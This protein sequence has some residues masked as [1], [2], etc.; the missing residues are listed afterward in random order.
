MPVN[1]SL[2]RL[3]TPCILLVLMVSGQ[4]VF[5]QRKVAIQTNSPQ[6][7]F[8]TQEILDAL[9]QIGA[10]GKL[11]L[12]VAIDESLGP[13]GYRVEIDEPG[14]VKVIGGDAHG[15]MY[16]ELEVAEQIRLTRDP[17]KVTAC[18]G[19]PYIGKRGLKFNIPLD[20]RAPSYD[21]TGDAAQKNIPVMWEYD[22]WTEFLDNMAR[23][24]YNVLT[25]WSTHPYPTLLPLEEYPGV[26]YDDV[27][28][29]NVEMAH[30]TDRHWNEIDIMD[31]ANTRVVKKMTIAE[32]TAFWQK[33]FQYA[34]DRG[35]EIYLFHWNIHM[36]GALGKHGISHAQD[37]PETQEY[38]RYCV[39]ELLLTYPQITGIGVTAGERVNRKLEGENSVENWM[40][41]TYGQGIM[42]AKKVNPDLDVRFIFRRHWADLGEIREAFKDFDGPFETGMKYARARMYTTPKPPFFDTWYR[43]ECE[44]HD[45]KCWMNV[46]NDDILF[47]RWGDPDYAREFIK[48]F[49]RDRMAGFYMG[50][51]GYVWGREFISKNPHEPRQLEIDKH[52]Y[53]FMIWGRL[54]Y[55][56][57]LDR[58]FF[59][60]KLAERFPE[61]KDS[62]ALYDAWASASKFISPVNL[63]HWYQNDLDWSPEGCFDKKNGFHDVNRF[64]NGQTQD[65]FL[66]RSMGE[67]SGVLSIKEY[68]PLVKTDEPITKMTP[69]ELSL[70]LALDVAESRQS[71]VSLAKSLD[72]KELNESELVETLRDIH[73]MQDLGLYYSDKVSGATQLQIYRVTG[74]KK[75]QDGAVS[76]LEN[77][78]KY[79]GR[80][81]RMASAVYHPQLYARTRLLDWNAILEHVEH[82]VEIARQDIRP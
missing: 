36:H 69:L 41:K 27:R 39:K 64:I 77:A 48:N 80:Y 58:E 82:D 79:W 75:W 32:K 26:A 17:L 78:V 16:G 34:E 15:A 45:I 43:E 81:A 9:G 37:D 70:N 66:G 33:V 71:L 23:H 59:E 53:R 55:N 61:V 11:Q 18:E 29:L 60:A 31:P 14:V 3:F 62:S 2:R 67:V 54:A 51:D 38:L 40:W 57:E 20:A 1:S 22:F 74:D 7:A 30:D 47:L 24:R 8:A 10:E 12:R 28:V 44:E 76:S 68:A 63:I 4:T 50:P 46:R 35:I 73:L 5:A 21:D 56:P 6:L 13:Q 19:K 42:D 49:P 65:N 72:P 52:W 25:L